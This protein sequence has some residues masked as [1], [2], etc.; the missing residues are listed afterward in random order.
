M[1]DIFLKQV[2]IFPT[3]DNLES[4]L[5]KAEMVA[6]VASGVDTPG[7]ARTGELCSGR[8]DGAADWWLYMRHLAVLET[9]AT[10][11]SAGNKMVIIILFDHT[12][13]TSQQHSNKH[14]KL[15]SFENREQ[16]LNNYCRI[17]ITS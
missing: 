16:I 10:R 9:L 11:A 4:C 14:F 8:A 2:D 12:T 6:V 13:H 5:G 7:H 3:F 1:Q 17:E 15:S